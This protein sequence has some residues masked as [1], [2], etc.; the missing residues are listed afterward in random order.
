MEQAT[1]VKKSR[2]KMNLTCFSSHVED[3]NYFQY[4]SI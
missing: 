4:L 2:M 1:T 3:S